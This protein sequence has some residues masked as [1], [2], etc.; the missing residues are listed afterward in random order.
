M[1]PKFDMTIGGRRV[2][3]THYTPIRNPAS[4]EVVGHAAV[5]DVR[6]GLQRVGDVFPRIARL[7]PSL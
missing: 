6:R 7:N 3:A 1:E 2:A 4:G 5:G